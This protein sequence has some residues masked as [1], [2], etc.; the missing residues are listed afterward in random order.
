MAWETITKSS[1][2][3]AVL[4]NLADYERARQTFAWE[5][6]RRELDGLPG[7]RGLN[8]AYEAVNRHANSALRDHLAIRWLV[9]NGEVE[10]YTYGQLQSLTNRFANSLQ[11]LGVN[12]GDRVY[13]LAGRIPELYVAALGTMKHGGVF[14]P[15]FSAFGPEPIR[16]RLTIGQAKVL[17]T[18]ELL[19]D[20]KVKA[21]QSSL[22]FLEHVVLIGSNRK[23]TSVPNTTDYLRSVRAY[24]SGLPIATGSTHRCSASSSSRRFAISTASSLRST[25]LWGC[26]VRV[27]RSKR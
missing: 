20:R 16:A 27:R 12:K 3:W 7:G 4:P 15:L 2:D 5:H 11:R 6:A 24:G 13:I 18:T 9:K 25:A 14:C 22:P 19:Y 17:I 21:L 26:W 8:I 10:D 1:R 23:P